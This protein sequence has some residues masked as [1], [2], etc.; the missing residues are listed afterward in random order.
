MEQIDLQKSESQKSYG[1]SAKN[2]D[3]YVCQLEMPR[4]QASKIDVQRETNY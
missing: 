2:M 1:K 4:I 3:E